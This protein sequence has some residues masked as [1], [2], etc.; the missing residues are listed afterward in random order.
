MNKLAT[1]ALRLALPSIL[2]SV[3]CGCRIAQSELQKSEIRAASTNAICKD[4]EL[5]MKASLK[6]FSLSGIKGFDLEG[7]ITISAVAGVVP[8]TVNLIQLSLKPSWKGWPGYFVSNA[9]RRKDGWEMGGLLDPKNRIFSGQS[10][11]E[12]GKYIIDF[13]WREQGTSGKPDHFA[14]Y[15]ISVTF[16]DSSGKRYI[17]ACLDVPAP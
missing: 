7:Q 12:N 1:F 6:K 3:T 4:G 11:L 13:V 10:K 5:S 14:A 17:I 9:N 8:G 2:I 16:S 15:D